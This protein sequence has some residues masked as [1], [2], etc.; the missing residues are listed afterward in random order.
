MRHGNTLLLGRFDAELSPVSIRVFPVGSAGL[1]LCLAPQLCH[2]LKKSLMLGGGGS[3]SLMGQKKHR[4][5][6]ALTLFWS[7]RALGIELLEMK[8][9]VERKR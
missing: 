1:C 6:S 7:H 9:V 4:L 3:V 8:N 2:Q 5:R